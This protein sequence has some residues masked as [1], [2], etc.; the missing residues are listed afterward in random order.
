[1]CPNFLLLER[2]MRDALSKKMLKESH[3]LKT[4]QW[5]LMMGL[6]GYLW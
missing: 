2:V 1:V 5:D 3:V 6:V 4:E